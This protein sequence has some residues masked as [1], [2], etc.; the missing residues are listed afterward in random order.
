MSPTGEFELGTDGPRKIVVGVDSS[1]AS[2]RAASFAAGLARR[3]RS[4]LV[5]VFVQKWHG[6]AVSP[7]EATMM[8]ERAEADLIA[9]FERELLAARARWGIEAS[10]I[11]RRGDPS[12]A[13][14]KVADEIRADAVV[15]GRSMKIGHERLGS[16]GGKLVRAGRWPVTI[17]P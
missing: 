1:D 6:T 3:Q 10:F 7:P 4:S 11:V 12:K 9:E 8:T 15:V 14:A 2:M 17:V 16:T 13:L 5:C